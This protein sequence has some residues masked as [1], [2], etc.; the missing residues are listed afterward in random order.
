MR[1]G[2]AVLSVMG[3]KYGTTNNPTGW[4]DGRLPCGMWGL[5][6]LKVLTARSIWILFSLNACVFRLV[7][8][9]RLG[10]VLSVFR[11]C[12]V[13][14]EPL[15]S[16]RQGTLCTRLSRG[17]SFPLDLGTRHEASCLSRRLEPSSSSLVFPVT[18]EFFLS[19]ATACLQVRHLAVPAPV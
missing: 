7:A 17:C 15:L 11:P 12:G 6:V 5:C 2:G 13:S 14:S 19:E 3:K 4:H 1:G 10:D 8:V 18:C 16:T 9:R